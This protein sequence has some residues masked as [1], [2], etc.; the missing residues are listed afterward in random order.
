MGL[1]GY[2]RECQMIIGR[3]RE[4]G[5][6]C[7]RGNQGMSIGEDSVILGSDDRCLYVMISIPF[8][9]CVI[10]TLALCILPMNASLFSFLSFSF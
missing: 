1:G 9:E 7:V 10:E 6:K 3:L 5:C 2:V 8:L 4:R